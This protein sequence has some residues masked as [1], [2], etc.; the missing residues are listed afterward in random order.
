MRKEANS[1]DVATPEMVSWLSSIAAYSAIPWAFILPMIAYS[2]GRKI[3]IV[4]ISVNV[5]VGNIV[6]YYSTNIIELFISQAT[7]GMLVSSALTVSVM[8]MSEYTSP[9]Y[10]GIFMT[11]K[12]A[13]FY[14]GVWVSN[15]IGTFYHWKNIGILVFVCGIYNLI[16]CIFC[17]ESPY[18]LATKGN[19]DDCAKVH[20]WLKGLD[21]I[22]EEELQ[23]LISSQK[24]H[25]NE[26]AKL[27]MKIKYSKSIKILNVLQCKGFYK[28]LL[29]ASLPIFLYN[30]SGKI[31]CSVYAI[32]IIKKITSSEQVAYQ[33]MLILDA[34]TVVGMYLGCALSKIVT[35]RKQLL[36]FSSTGVVVLYVLS[37]YLYM[38][39]V[40]VI[41][42]NN[43]V[44]L[45]FLMG[46]SIS[47]SCGPMIL[48]SS[49]C[50]ELSPLRYRSYFVC[51]LGLI[52]DIVFA[53]ILKI[54][55]LVFKYWGTHGAF[56]FYAVSASVFVCL[57][58][59]YMPETKDKTIQEIQEGIV[60]VRKNATVTRSIQL[61][62]LKKSEY[63][64]HLT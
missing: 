60:G 34:V 26:K 54:S 39:E 3:S 27:N 2:F 21:E 44:T 28:P 40:N 52:A 15:A 46:Y 38:I 17:Y 10:R 37:I 35:R 4:L 13:T 24:Q 12:G 43:Y 23:K 20:R 53:T 59:K 49:C 50:A 61:V 63:T 57:I 31:A 62:P 64:L 19:F 58:Y 16:S 22:S 14:W 41:S 33:G 42:E 9:K 1:T 5:F 45:F 47:I 36:L 32:D 55:P 51:C 18:W 6:F 29:Y 30:L 25:F 11:F 48:A 56:L 7:L 8:V